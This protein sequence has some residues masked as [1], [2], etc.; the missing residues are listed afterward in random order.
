MSADEATTEAP[1]ARDSSPDDPEAGAGHPEV[2]RGGQRVIVVNSQPRPGEEELP[3]RQMRGLGSVQTHATGPV[4]GGEQRRRRASTGSS[5]TAIV[6][7][8]VPVLLA[9]YV[10]TLIA[11]SSLDDTFVLAATALLALLWLGGL[12]SAWRGLGPGG[13]DGRSGVHFGRAVGLV[14]GAV[15]AVYLLIEVVPPLL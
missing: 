6:T 2:V 15:G 3:P 10:I 9:A 7:T 4:S 13:R 14:V 12:V 1:D 11:D 5:L 8:A